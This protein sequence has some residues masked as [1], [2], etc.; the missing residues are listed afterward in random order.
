MNTFPAVGK[1]HGEPKSPQTQG[2]ELVSLRVSAPDGKSDVVQ[3]HNRADPDA[4]VSHTAYDDAWFQLSEDEQ[5]NLSRE[6]SIKS[7]FEK[8]DETDAADQSKTLLKRGKMKVGLGYVSIICG[9]IDLVTPW[10][11]VPGLDAGVCLFKGIVAVGPP[12]IYRP[13]ICT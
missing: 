5:S 8:L 2:S 12:C 11:P 10:I 6:T 4:K 7:L 13:Y 3:P 9:Y 1:G